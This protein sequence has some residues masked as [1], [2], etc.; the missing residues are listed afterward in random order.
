MVAGKVDQNLTHHSRHE[1]KEMDPVL[2]FAIGRLHESYESLIHQY[3]TVEHMPRAVRRTCANA[4]DG[5]VP[6]R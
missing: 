6:H 2:P 3:L 4:P 5:E 1:R